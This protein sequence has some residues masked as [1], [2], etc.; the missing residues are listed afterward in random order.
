MDNDFNPF[1][2]STPKQAVK[3]PVKEVPVPK[4]TVH[5]VSM[6]PLFHSRF[7]KV[8]A[9]ILSVILAGLVGYI[10]MN[11]YLNTKTVKSSQSNVN[12]R[13]VATY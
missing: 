7:T 10:S 1:D 6:G 3:E 5:R 13:F 12:R 9:L 4:P 8:L 2:L 11:Y